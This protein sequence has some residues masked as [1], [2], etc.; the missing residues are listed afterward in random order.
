M[1]RLGEEN[2]NSFGTLMRIIEY[3]NTSNITVEFQDEYKFRKKTT[4][5]NFKMGT[6]KNPYDKTIFGI[7]CLGD[8]KYGTGKNSRGKR[9]T[10]LNWIAMLQRCYV[11][12]DGKYPAY[13]G[14]A[15]VCDAWLNYQNFA[16]WY[17]NNY[18]EI[19]N[20]RLHIDK[21]ILYK[22]N[23]IYSPETCML[24]PQ[25]INEVFRE[26]SKKAKDK[27]LPETIRRYREKYTVSF[28]GRKIGT[29]KTVDECLKKYNHE[30]S[31]YIK[32]MVRHYG[33]LLPDNVIHA[34]LTW[35]G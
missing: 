25:T 11:D 35:N 31:F 19:P 14:I 33:K 10:Y 3:K 32:D 28:R 23:K 5:S 1:S 24:I 18:Y 29:Y 8:G 27:D 34:L 30:K 12:M 20:E 4:Y 6:V 2:F 9:D 17:E 15:T 7:A 16:E 21:D 26:N 13:Y 22:G